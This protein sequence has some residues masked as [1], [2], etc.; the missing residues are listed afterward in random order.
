[1][2]HHDDPATTFEASSDLMRATLL[3]SARMMAT[4]TRH[5]IEFW[6]N[7][8][9]NG[10][11]PKQPAA[12]FGLDPFT[13]WTAMMAPMMWPGQFVRPVNVR[14]TAEPAASGSVISS[15]TV[16]SAPSDVSSFST[17]YRSAGGFAVAQIA[18][19]PNNS[20]QK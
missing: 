5:T 7:M 8:A 18:E 15:T 3:L 10:L 6:S 4:T 14:S 12:A 13:T 11:A 19:E 1:M 20:Q 2:W 9:A 17:N 16:V